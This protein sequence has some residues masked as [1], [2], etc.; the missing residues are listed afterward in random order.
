[1]SL[2]NADTLALRGPTSAGPWQPVIFDGGGTWQQYQELQSTSSAPWAALPSG[3]NVNMEAWRRSPARS[4]EFS[5][6]VVVVAGQAAL[7]GM[8]V[9]ILSFPVPW[10][11]EGLPWWSF[12]PVGL[13]SFAVATLA[14]LRSNRRHLWNEEHV[15][16]ESPEPTPEVKPE[17]APEPIPEPTFE[18][19]HKSEKGTILSVQRFSHLPQN[20]LDNLASFAQQVE[21]KGLSEATWTGKAGV[22][23]KPEYT[24]LMVVLHEAGIVEWV[25]PKAKAQGRQVTRNGKLALA[26]LAKMV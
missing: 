12:G 3:D 14:L 21:F 2:G 6:D 10:M 24:A 5:A 22:F 20:V 13:G 23:S 11:V 4:P 26:H 9:G 7:I 8:A 19:I 1:M 16:Q 17:L 18:V 25:N 15:S